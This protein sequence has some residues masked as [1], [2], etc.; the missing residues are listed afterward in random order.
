MLK[1]PLEQFHRLTEFWRVN[2]VPVFPM[3]LQKIIQPQL[4]GCP[5]RGLQ[6]PPNRLPV[7]FDFAKV[8]S[9]DNVL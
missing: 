8:V 6:T 9:A 5:N 3:L 4:S 1:L 7:N 2:P